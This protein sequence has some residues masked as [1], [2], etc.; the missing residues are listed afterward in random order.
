MFADDSII[1]ITTPVVKQEVKPVFEIKTD[2]EVSDVVISDF[3]AASFIWLESDVSRTRLFNI[4]SITMISKI[5][6][7]PE[8]PVLKHFEH[9]L[10][11]YAYSP[12]Y[13]SP[14]PFRDLI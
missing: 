12:M 11:S 2:Q 7:L 9:P 1:V 5:A 8:Y 13:F 14:T 3:K 10:G 4:S 6:S